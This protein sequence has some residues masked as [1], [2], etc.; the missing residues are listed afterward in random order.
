MG[1]EIN[2]QAREE[3][4]IE[5]NGISDEN[6]NRKPSENR[7][8]IKQVLEH[9]YLMEGAITKNIGSQL[10]HGEFVDTADKPI[11][12]SVDRSRKVDAPGFSQPSESFVTLAE[13]KQK[14]EATHSGLSELADTSDEKLLA[15][16]GFEHSVFGQMSLKQWIPFVGYHEK[17]HTEQIKEVKEDLG[18]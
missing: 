13:L 16:R 17:R 4:L 1:L 3:L 14:L 2:N 12:L 15:E 9:L 18:L 5:V 11:E 7:W 8:S 10:A 6:L